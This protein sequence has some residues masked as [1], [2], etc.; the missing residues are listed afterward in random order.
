MKATKSVRLKVWLPVYLFSAFVILSAISLWYNYT[1]QSTLLVRQSTENIRRTLSLLSDTLELQIDNIDSFVTKRAIATSAMDP[2]FKNLIVLDSNLN[3]LASNSNLSPISGKITEYDYFSSAHFNSLQ[4]T[5]KPLFIVDKAHKRILVYFP[6]KVMNKQNQLRPFE[7]G[8]I[9]AN[10]D[11]KV[12]LS[13]LVAE[14]IKESLI[15]SALLLML[16]ATIVI[17]TFRYIS[18]PINHLEKVTTLLARNEADARANIT[19]KGEFANLALHFNKMAKELNARLIQRLR[20]EQDSKHREELL[21]SVII[22]IDDI[23]FILDIDG[24]ILD[25]K[26]GKPENLYVAPEDFLN[27]NVKDILP[28][29][30]AAVFMEKIQLAVERNDLIRFRYKLFFKGK[31]RYFEARIRVLSNKA[32]VI[33]VLRDINDQVRAEKKMYE[34]ANFDSLTGLPNRLLSLGTLEQL[35]I[36]QKAAQKAFAV[37]FIDLD[38]FKKI[39][40]TLGHETGDKLL[41]EMAHRIRSKLDASDTIGRLGGDEFIVLMK[42]DTSLASLGAKVQ[43]LVELF[44]TPLS[45]DNR[46]LLMSV[47]IGVSTYPD[48][49]H[50][51][52]ELIRKADSAMYHAKSSGRNMFCFYSATMNDTVT[53]RLLIEEQMHGALARNEFSVHLQPQISLCDR[54][55]IGA[56]ALLRWDNPKLGKLSPAEFIPIAEQNGTIV[57]IGKFVLMQVKMV[58][59]SWEKEGFSGLRIAANL[60]PRQLKDA[61]FIPFLQELVT[62]MHDNSNHLE[63]EVTEGVLLTGLRD[64]ELALLEIHK[65]GVLLAMDDFGTGYSSLNYLRKYPFGVLKIDKSFIDDIEEDVEDYRLIEAI[66]NMSHG[67]NLK[68]VAEG[69]ETLKQAEI[70]KTLNCDIAQGYYFSKPVSLKEF[71][72]WREGYKYN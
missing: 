23:F 45:I 36:E 12:D 19:G 7:S 43:S 63:L 9:F 71:E 51:V 29:D 33:A 26:T 55:F 17:F 64:V 70:L 58:L 13:N 46:N 38:D 72:V 66:V 52:T 41:I 27:E 32:R 1:V 6:L 60:S 10:Y 30:V 2:H 4:K 3:V 25:Y 21:N 67:M 5:R 40:D 15:M 62:D 28:A 69:V 56:E 59:D 42:I 65:L 14:S 54:Q 34:Q 11:L 31:E 49:G 53:R 8:A 57:D 47:S 24:K 16:L 37:I 48:D 18:L 35:I 61:E 44:K 68:V 22:S 39:N 50:T 20:A